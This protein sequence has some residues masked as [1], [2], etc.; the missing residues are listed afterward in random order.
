MLVQALPQ[1]EVSLALRA[2]S[3]PWQLESPGSETHVHLRGPPST[4]PGSQLRGLSRGSAPQV[5]SPSWHHSPPPTPA[6][7]LASWGRLLPHSGC[8]AHVSPAHPLSS[9]S[10]SPLL[11]SLPRLWPDLVPNPEETPGGPWWAVVTAHS[12]CQ[13]VLPPLMHGAAGQAGPMWASEPETTRP[14]PGRCRLQSPLCLSLSRVSQE[15][16]PELPQLQE[17]GGRQGLPGTRRLRGLSVINTVA[18]SLEKTWAQC[19]EGYRC[20]PW[21]KSPQLR[22]E[23]HWD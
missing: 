21:A 17:C 23:G 1:P 14:R 20:G 19:W 10:L 18:L 6:S 12:A 8:G 5:W 22:P 16:P 9:G 3:T 7:A 2:P 4:L 11:G 13:T 15:I